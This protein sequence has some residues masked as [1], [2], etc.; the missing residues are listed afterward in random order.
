MLVARFGEMWGHEE[1]ALCLEF[2]S[3]LLVSCLARFQFAYYR[4][5]VSFVFAPPEVPSVEERVATRVALFGENIF[6]TD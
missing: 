6:Q 3:W 5:A 4:I 2:R 1:T